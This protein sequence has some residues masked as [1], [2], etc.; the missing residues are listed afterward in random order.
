MYQK[1]AVQTNQEKPKESKPETNGKVEAQ[2]EL[3]VVYCPPFLLPKK[4]LEKLKS[5]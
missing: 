3:T 5:E 4:A 1:K 2:T